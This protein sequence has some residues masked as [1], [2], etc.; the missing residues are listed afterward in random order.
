MELG[1]V[2]KFLGK[3]IGEEALRDLEWG[4]SY[5]WLKFEMIV[6]GTSSMTKMLIKL[7]DGKTKG[8]T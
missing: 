2:V 6:L 8:N 3:L 7:L 4:R 5:F 1:E